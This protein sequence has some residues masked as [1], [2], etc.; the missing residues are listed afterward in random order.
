[1]SVDEVHAASSQ[2]PAR[3]RLMDE[4]GVHAQIVYPNLAGF[5]NQ[6]FMRVQDSELRL[7][8]AQIYNDAGAEHQEQSGDRIFTMALVPWWDIEASVTE[9]RR[10]A[11]MGMRGVVMCSKIGRA[12]V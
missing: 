6:A 5:G 4:V 10:C 11:A 3:L 12:H 7:L 8:C 1:M 9:V 2:I